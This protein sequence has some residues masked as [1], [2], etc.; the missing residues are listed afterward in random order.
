MSSDRRERQLFITPTFALQSQAQ[1]RQKESMMVRDVSTA[2]LGTGQRLVFCDTTATPK[3]TRI[4]L[5]RL[6]APGGAVGFQGMAQRGH[7]A[8]DRSERC[9]GGDRGKGKRHIF[10]SASARHRGVA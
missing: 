6:I 10:A 4:S 5:D 7:G 1:P 8:S 2:R 9:L 3:V